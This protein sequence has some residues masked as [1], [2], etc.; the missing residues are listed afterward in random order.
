MLNYNITSISEALNTI[1]L[2]LGV[3]LL[4]K[5]IVNCIYNEVK[6]ANLVG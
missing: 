3:M 4:R 6:R 5:L 2:L 1:A